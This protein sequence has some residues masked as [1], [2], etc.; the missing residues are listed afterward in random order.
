MDWSRPKWKK[1]IQIL[2]KI[3]WKKL[4]AEGRGI[5]KIVE[6]LDEYNEGGREDD[7]DALNGEKEGLI[8]YRFRHEND[9]N[10]YQW[11]Q[12]FNKID[13]Y[14]KLLKFAHEHDLVYLVEHCKIR[15]AWKILFWTKNDSADVFA[16]LQKKA[17]D[18]E[19]FKDLV[20]F[21]EETMS[22]KKI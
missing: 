1:F 12:E 2:K 15:L 11:E 17:E 4:C 7:W 22:K 13:I 10:W 20:R 9:T 19:I 6:H 3:S 14:S 5:L 21:A 18:S 16:D 8:S